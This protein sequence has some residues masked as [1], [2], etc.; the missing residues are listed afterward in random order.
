MVNQ[1]KF[2]FTSKIDK[3]MVDYKITFNILSK[4]MGILEREIEKVIS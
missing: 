1:N 3:K 2:V 4:A